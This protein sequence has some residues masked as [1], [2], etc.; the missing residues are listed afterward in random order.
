MDSGWPTMGE[1]KTELGAY[2][3][4]VASWVL[5][6][7]L[8]SDTIEPEIRAAYAAGTW[9]LRRPA[10]SKLIGRGVGT[11]TQRWNDGPWSELAAEAW[12]HVDVEAILDFLF[13]VVARK[14]M[15]SSAPEV[16]L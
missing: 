8:F 9:M 5:D 11:P 3:G 16:A 15:R 14:A 13:A 4:I 7:A 1:L 2:N 6:S 12:E 10:L